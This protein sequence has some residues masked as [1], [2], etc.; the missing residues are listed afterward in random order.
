MAQQYHEYF[1]PAQADKFNDTIGKKDS[2]FELTYFGLH[3]LG[4]TA[5]EIIYASGGKVK[6]IIVTNENWAEKKPFAPF[7]LVPLLKETSS[8]GTVVQVAE[9]D[10]IERYLSR[11]FGLFGD[12]AFEETV[13]NT[14]VSNISGLFTD[15]IQKYFNFSE[16]ERE[17]KKESIFNG[18][19]APWIK[20]HERH[21][22][23]NKSN[24]HYVG[25]KLT[26]AD[27]KSSYA[28]TSILAIAPEGTI[29][30]T[31]TPGLWNLK[32]TV[33][34]IPSL[35]AWRATDEYKE[36]QAE[37]IKLLGF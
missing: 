3:G 36:F 31:N 16:A 13:V 30:E 14:F 6:N 37:N 1:N 34:K 4:N 11:K 15:L 10:S 35:A 8:D 2:T 21:L 32:N 22:A 19:V 28:I 33:D 9:S 29:S 20:H 25:N 5:R 24:G 18:V 7:G 17:A 23:A 26:L 27:I 12:N